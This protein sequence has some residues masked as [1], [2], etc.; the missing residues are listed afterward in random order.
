MS[1]AAVTVNRE[2]GTAMA[3]GVGSGEL[4]G[5]SSRILCVVKALCPISHFRRLIQ[6]GMLNNPKLNNTCG[7]GSG[8]TVIEVNIALPYKYTAYPPIEGIAPSE[9]VNSWPTA[10]SST[11]HCSVSDD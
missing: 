9:N 3:N 4:L 7:D 10:Q 11:F 5:D 8:T 6:K 1:R 2:C